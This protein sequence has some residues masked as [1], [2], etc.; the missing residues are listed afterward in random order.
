MRVRGNRYVFL[1]ALAT[2]PI[3]GIVL[4]SEDDRPGPGQQFAE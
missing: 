1:M 2:V 4:G 3:A